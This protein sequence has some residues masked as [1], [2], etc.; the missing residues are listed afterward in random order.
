MLYYN[1]LNIHLPALFLESKNADRVAGK[2]DGATD[3][4]KNAQ[5]SD[6]TLSG[7]ASSRLDIVTLNN[8][9]EEL[10]KKMMEVTYSSRPG[11]RCKSW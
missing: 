8:K 9:L 3:R 6:C 4:S 11:R 1:E 7:G 5:K 2:T 10:I